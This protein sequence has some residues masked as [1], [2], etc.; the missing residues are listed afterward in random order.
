MSTQSSFLAVR[1]IGAVFARTLW[2]STLIAA[3]LI[4]IASI[5]LLVWLVPLSGWWWLL[6]APIGIGISV[7]IALLVIFHLLIRYVQPANQTLEQ[8]T[9]IAAFVQKLQFASEITGTPKIIMLFRTIRSIAAPKSDR[10]LQD[11]FETKNLRKDFHTII[12]SFEN[13]IDQK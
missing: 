2:Q 10:Y 3:L 8:K 11:I 5:A 4:S 7:A 9:L 13:S 1:A 6:A 12:S